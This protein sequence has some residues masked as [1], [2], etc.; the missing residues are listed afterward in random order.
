MI[1]IPQSII[2]SDKF[3]AA[4]GHFGNKSNKFV[5]DFAVNLGFQYYP[6]TTKKDFL[7]ITKSLTADQPTNKPI[8]VEVFTDITNENEALK[9]IRNLVVNEKTQSS[10]SVGTI[11]KTAI[12][13]WLAKD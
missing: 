2:D 13:K 8:L 4:A 3:I 12:K 11:T 5:C 1:T 10:L 7:D 9:L 6:V